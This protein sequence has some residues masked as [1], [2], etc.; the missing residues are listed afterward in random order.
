MA[1]DQA[2]FSTMHECN[3]KQIFVG[4]DS[5]LSVAGS[6]TVPIYNGHFSDVLCVPIISCNLLSVYQITHFGEGK[7]VTFTPHQVVIKDFKYP[8]HVLA[9]RIVGD[10]TRL[11][12]FNNFGSSPFLSVFVAHSDNLANFGMS[13]LVT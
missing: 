4:D 10:I 3:T 9:T 7:I 13:D 8:Q 1:E 6:I 5:S 12:N 11:Y 2:I